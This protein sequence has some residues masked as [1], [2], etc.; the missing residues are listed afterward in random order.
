MG[1]RLIFLVL[2]MSK[3]DQAARIKARHGDEESFA[4]HLSKMYDVYEPASSDE[5]NAIHCLVT[6]DM[7]KDDVVEKITRLL[8]EH[9]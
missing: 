5:P 8:K 7:S 9:S 6:K 1:P 4:E 3:E 2:H